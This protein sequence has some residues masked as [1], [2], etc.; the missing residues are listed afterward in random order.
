MERRALIAVAGA[1]AAML[2]AGSVL[3][4]TREA[5]SMHPAKYKALEDAAGRCVSTGNDCIR[6]CLG[7]LAMN[8][9]SMAACNAAAYEL[10]AA[11]VALQTLAAVNSRNLPAFAKAVAAI[12][13][14]CQKECEKF[15]HFA[16]CSA[17]AAACTACAEQCGKVTA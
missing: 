5:V 15:P 13:L 4:Q 6:H 14:V 17:C 7:M 11:C 2:S 12:C 3:A 8:D 1:T 9:V 10:V 16:E